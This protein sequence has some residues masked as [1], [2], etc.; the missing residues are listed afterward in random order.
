MN[1]KKERNPPIKCLVRNLSTGGC[2]ISIPADSMQEI[3]KRLFSLS[4]EEVAETLVQNLTDGICGEEYEQPV[5]LLNLGNW[6]I[7][8]GEYRMTGDSAEENLRK[9]CERK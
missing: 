5:A 8:N 1:M 4:P 6:D 9:V 2:L 3:R 7:V